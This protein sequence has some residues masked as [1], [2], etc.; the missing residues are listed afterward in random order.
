M[1]SVVILKIN[2]IFTEIVGNVPINDIDKILS[3]YVPGYLFSPKYA[4][5]IVC[6]K[7][8]IDRKTGCCPICKRH[9]IW[10]GKKHLLSVKKNLP[11]VFPTG[12]IPQ[13]V[14]IL[15]R[16][17][18]DFTFE[19]NRKNFFP[20]DIQNFNTLQLKNIDLWETQK[21]TVLACIENG[22]G[23]IQSPTS[24]GKSVCMAALCKIYKHN[25]LILI[26]KKSIANQLKNEIEAMIEETVGFIG[27]GI[28][29]PKRVTVGMTASLAYGIGISGN[30]E[31]ENNPEI[32]RV[33][34]NCTMLIGDE[35][36]HASSNSWF[37]LFKYCT[38][39]YYRLGFTGTAFMKTEGEN[40]LL[41][42][43]TGPL[44]FEVEEE[45]LIQ[46]EKMARP[47]IHIY[48]IPH[49]DTIEKQNDYFI[50]TNHK[51]YDKIDFS[52]DFPIPEI[53]Q[54]N[55]I[56]NDL[57]Y[58]Q[59]YDKLIVNNTY[60]NYISSK[61][62]EKLYYQK[63]QILV[64]FE[65]KQHIQN[66]SNLLIYNNLLFTILS[67]D[68]DEG[69]RQEIIEEFKKSKVQIILATKIFDEG[70]SIHNIDVVVRMGLLKTH[71]KSKQQVGRGQ[72][73]K[74]DKP[75][76]VHI[77]DFNH[78]TNEYLKKHS[79]EHIKLYKKMNYEIHYEN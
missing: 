74:K 79:K 63:Q 19:D 40:L 23:V 45:Q 22:R 47:I 20:I 69:Y 3:F 72:R 67:G 42:A 50:K 6:R 51:N 62:V 28:C 11:P 70:I 56:N 49:A 71:I 5:C 27:D 24:S 76:E 7:T 15:Q 75:N 41:Q 9:R 38:N 54:P 30:K 29:E 52:I 34:R 73:N 64:L 12:C 53:Y 39:A 66:Y 33:L 44:L 43:S 18:I 55:Y 58:Q 14:E 78:T 26:D 37:L 31:Q 48:S 77:V 16:N 68:D 8:K 13:V 36:H 61:I 46:E 65:H 17:H 21:D 10:D 35:V 25:V 59:A 2:N 4:Y 32:E 60:F 57:T 1:S